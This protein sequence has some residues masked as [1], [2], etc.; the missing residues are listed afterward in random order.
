MHEC[1]HCKHKTITSFRKLCST[2]LTPAVCPRCNGLSYLQLVYLL[3]AMI[4]WVVL[5]WVFIGVALYQRMSIYLLGSIPALFFAV[6][7]CMMSAPL[8]PIDLSD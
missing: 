3:R 4:T 2:S 1:P 6:D 7:K 5:S 8:W